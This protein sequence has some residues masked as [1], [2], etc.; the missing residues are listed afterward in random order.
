MVIWDT[1]FKSGP[2]KSCGKQ[3]LKNYTWSTPEY[4]APH[5]TSISA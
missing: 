1:L 4:F 5:N 2:S 3:P